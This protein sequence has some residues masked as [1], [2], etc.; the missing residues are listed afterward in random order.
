[1][2]LNTTNNTPEHC[3]HCN[4]PLQGITVVGNGFCCQGCQAVYHILH[5]EGLDRF[6]ELAPKD[7]PPPN[8]EEEKGNFDSF[9]WLDGKDSVGQLSVG[10][11]GIHCTACVWLFEEMFEREEGAK[12]IIVNPTMGEIQFDYDPDNFDIKS[13]FQKMEAFGYRFGER[14]EEQERA[15]QALLW[16]VGVSIALTMNVMLIYISFYFGLTPSEELFPVFAWVAFALSTINVVVGG[17]PFLRS[18]WVLI[19]LRSLHLDL[20]IAVGIVFSYLGSFIAFFWGNAELT[21]FD[22]LSSFIS[23]MLLGRFLQTRSIENNRQKIL[24]DQQE[25]DWSCSRIIENDTERKTETVLIQQLRIGDTILIPVGAVVPVAAILDSPSQVQ[26]NLAWMTGE[27]EP[28]QATKGMVLRSGAVNEGT[29]PFFCI[30]TEEW[31]KSELQELLQRTPASDGKEDL[32]VWFRPILQWYVPIV[33]VL[34]A[35]GFLLWIPEGL[36]RAMEVVTAILIVT[37]PCAFGI[38][39]P[40]AKELAVLNLRK[41]GVFVQSSRFFVE[42]NQITQIVFDKT[43]T[44][45]LGKLEVQ[46]AEIFATLT[47]V[48]RLALATMV[49]QSNHPK[50]KAIATYVKEEKLQK[51]IVR[52]RAGQ[53][54]YM[55]EWS[56]V[57]GNKQENTVFYYQDKM[58]ASFQF[59]EKPRGDLGK[60]FQILQ[61]YGKRLVLLSGDQQEKVDRLLIQNNIQNV[62]A[63]GALSPKDKANWIAEHSAK[64]TMMVGDG[65]NDSQAFEVAALT[66]TP[67]NHLAELL[68][69]SD[70]YFVGENIASILWAIQWGRQTQQVQKRAFVMALTYNSSVIVICLLGMMTPLWAAIAMPLSSIVIVLDTFLQQRNLREKR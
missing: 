8:A 56:L 29:E 55:G 57:K 20:P 14:R 61:D 12:E 63:M 28:I 4:A 27:S 30:V 16:R 25:L 51:E 50:S 11:Q 3:L 60:L 23:L 54:L 40:L 21:Y 33:F 53:G 59:R 1:M 34:A 62:T 64:T 45:T 24:Q 10:V 13:F 19:R 52:E 58:I 38:A 32:P 39:M 6:Y 69:R 42:I 5:Q 43:G 15:S 44:L 46:N 17:W 31:N 65:L 49:H 66:A 68:S 18:A 70:V 67:A 36:G 48:Q 41:R 7:L 9:A 22:S 47:T 26:I 37:C 35:L 2:S